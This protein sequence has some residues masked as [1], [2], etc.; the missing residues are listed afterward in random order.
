MGDQGRVWRR[1]RGSVA[2]RQQPHPAPPTPAPPPAPHA[3]PHLPQAPAGY[4]F[5]PGSGL[6]YSQDSGL[7]WDPA[8]G[9]FYSADSGQWY[10]WDEGRQQFVEW[11]SAAGR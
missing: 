3:P 8:T 6:W 9:G 4:A 7:H 1:C 5:D 2:C 11:S 10:G